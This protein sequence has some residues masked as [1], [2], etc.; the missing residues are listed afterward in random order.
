MKYL[1]IV[2]SLQKSEKNEDMLVLVRSGVFFYGIGKDAIILTQNLR[3]N[4]CC[5]KKQICKVAIPVIKINNIIQKLKEKGISFVIYDYKPDGIFENREE[6]YKELVRYVNVPISEAREHFE[7][8]KCQFHN[9]YEN[10]CNKEKKR[11]EE[12][13]KNI[14]EE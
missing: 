3:L 11:M 4:Y 6:K 7:C 2:K 13:I 5:I 14:G 9:L 8:S 10:K 12:I 1:E